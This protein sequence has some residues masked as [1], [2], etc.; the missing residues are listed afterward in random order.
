MLTIFNVNYSKL[1]Y[2]PHIAENKNQITKLILDYFNERVK[3]LVSVTEYTVDFVLASDLSKIWV[4]ELN[5][6]P[7]VASTALFDW[8]NKDEQAE[9]RSLPF[10]LRINEAPLLE[11]VLRS[12]IY[13]PILAFLASI[14]PSFVSWDRS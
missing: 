10:K 5:N 13:W 3:P 2:V 14:S 9:M 6:P 4:I 1:S 7:P 8:S 12:S 11:D